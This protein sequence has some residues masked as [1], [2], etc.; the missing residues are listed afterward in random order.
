MD[1]ISHKI[2]KKIKYKISTPSKISDTYIRNFGEPFL[3]FGKFPEFSNDL[4][5]FKLREMKKKESELYYMNH[6]RNALLEGFIRRD[7]QK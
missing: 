5:K 2:Q 4:G 1:N 3:I 7:D 6:L